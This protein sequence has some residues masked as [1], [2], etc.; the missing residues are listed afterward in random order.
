MERHVVPSAAEAGCS[1]FE[2]FMLEHGFDQ[3]VHFGPDEAVATCFAGESNVW[4]AGAQKLIAA[5]VAR[6]R[7]Q[8]PKLADSRSWLVTVGHVAPPPVHAT[9]LHDWA[10]TLEAKPGQARRGWRA[11][12]GPTP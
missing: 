7:L 1:C 6:Q 3:V 12:I 10:S 4:F 11:R 2:R 8:S 5:T 9:R